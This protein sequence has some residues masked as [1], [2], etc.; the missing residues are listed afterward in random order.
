MEATAARKMLLHQEHGRIAIPGDE[1]VIQRLTFLG[2]SVFAFVSVTFST[3]QPGA[4]W[5][6]RSSR[7]AGSAPSRLPQAR[8]AGRF[9]NG[10]ASHSS[11]H[12]P[13]PGTPIIPR[14]TYASV[15]TRMDA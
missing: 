15:D 13:M 3:G 10:P 4:T 11:G 8:T 1:G 6:S 14:L 7:S 12:S 5:W 9:T 2:K